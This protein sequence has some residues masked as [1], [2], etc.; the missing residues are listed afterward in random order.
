MNKRPTISLCIFDLDGVIVDTAKYHF[1][2]WKKLAASFGYELTKEKN[3]NLK[4][5]S[6]VESLEYIL[7]W[8]GVSLS[9]TEK[10]KLTTEKN[11]QYV[12][13]IQ[14]LGAGEA[15][16]GVVDFIHE[17][18]A[19]NVKTAIGSASKNARLILEQLEIID[20]FDAIVD[21]TMTKKGKPD[22]EVFLLGAKMTDSLPAETVVFED[23]VK[24]VDAALAAKMTAIGIGET[25]QLG[26][27]HF[28]IPGFSDFKYND[29][30]QKTNR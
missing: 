19:A 12:K 9:E 14:K 3:E 2:S 18:R 29:F 1:L 21:G 30:I 7:E 6:R 11:E 16:T 24:G 17:L 22:P 4:G 15:L 28:V 8:A 5:V 10:E 25:A 26:H 13:S 27:A 20:L 23:A